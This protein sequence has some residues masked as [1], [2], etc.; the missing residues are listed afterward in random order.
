MVFEHRR[1]ALELVP[2]AR[3]RRDRDGRCEP[4]RV[5]TSEFGCDRT[6]L[7]FRR[8]HAELLGDARESLW[9]RNVSLLPSSEDPAMDPERRRIVGDRGTGEAVGCT[10]D[11]GLV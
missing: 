9:E 10:T 11:P 8:N 2:H 5:E 3:E 4:P 6:A 7:W 1:Q